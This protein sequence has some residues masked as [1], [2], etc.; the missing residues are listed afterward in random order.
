[1]TVRTWTFGPILCTG[2]AIVSA[3]GLFQDKE[4]VVP[5]VVIQF[6]ILGAARL[7]EMLPNKILLVPLIKRELS[8]NP[9]EFN[10]KEHT[11]I[12]LFACIGRIRPDM[13]QTYLSNE[14]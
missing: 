1:M 13:L 2:M 11:L 4:L 10:Y 6:I 5:M 7:T 8:L 14:N 9:C 12:S 3:K